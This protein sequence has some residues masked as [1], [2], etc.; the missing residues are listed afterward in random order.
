MGKQSV[1]SKRTFEYL[2]T[3][4]LKYDAKPH[5]FNVNTKRIKIDGK[6]NDSSIIFAASAVKSK[7]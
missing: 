2:T 5:E 4:K 6:P 3:I 7:L 1:G